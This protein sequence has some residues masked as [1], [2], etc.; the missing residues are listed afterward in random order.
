MNIKN[1]DLSHMEHEDYVNIQ[2][3]NGYIVLTRT[4]VGFIIDF[5]DLDDNCDHTM[6][7][8]DDELR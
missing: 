2:L 7:V 3:A 6:S 1:F 8:W 5:Y 4:D